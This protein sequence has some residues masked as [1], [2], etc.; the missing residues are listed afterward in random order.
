MI[1]RRVKAGMAK[2][3]KRMGHPPGAPAVGGGKPA[4]VPESTLAMI[5][6]A[7]Q[8]GITP[9]QIADLLNR[10]KIAS[11]RGKRWHATTIKRLLARLDGMALRRE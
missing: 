10:Y 6:D 9:Q 11:V 3:T 1:S 7:R 8:E 5:R 4:K 2:S